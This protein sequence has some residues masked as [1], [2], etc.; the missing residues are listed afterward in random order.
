MQ[1]EDKL[2]RYQVNAFMEEMLL[3]FNL[4]EDEVHQII[5]EMRW[6]HKRRKKYEYYG[7]WI[8]KS[9]ITILVTSFFAALGW[10]FIHF[11]QFING[12]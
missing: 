8:A 9:I 7:D 10:G 1:D 12:K 2:A 5:D 11:I 4:D 3:R 6:L